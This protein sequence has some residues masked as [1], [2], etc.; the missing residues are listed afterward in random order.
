MLC[1]LKIQLGDIHEKHYLNLVCKVTY[2]KFCQNVFSVY[3]S[4]SLARGTE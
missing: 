1:F 2:Y 3:R 4:L